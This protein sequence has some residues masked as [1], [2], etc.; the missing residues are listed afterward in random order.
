MT[1]TTAKSGEGPFVLILASAMGVSLFIF[2]ALAALSPQ[3]VADLG[4]SRAQLGALTTVLFA[5]SGV[6]A[7]VA[8]RIVDAVGGRRVLMG[9]FVLSAAG[10]AAVALS[11]S[12]V[13]MLVGVGI[14]GL[15]L[16]AANPATNHLVQ[17]FAAPGRRGVLIGLKQ[18]GV[19]VGAFAA[20]AIL[21]AAAIEVGWR[22]VLLGAAVLGLAWAVPAG[23]VLPAPPPA[24]PSSSRP[25]PAPL[26]VGRLAFYAGCMGAAIAPVGSYLPLYA[27]EQLG[28]S[29][30]V[31]GMLPAVI[32][33]IGIFS[34]VA[35][36]RYAEK[37]RSAA[38][39]LLWLAVFSVGAQLM[40]LL[41]AASPWLVWI[42]AVGFGASATSWSAVGM[43]AV[44]REASAEQAG[45]ASGWL[46]LGFHAGLVA[47]PIA[48]GAL[49]DRTGSYRWAWTLLLGCFAAAAAIAWR[50]QA[51]ERRRDAQA[52][53][54]PG[55]HLHPSTLTGNKEIT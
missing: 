25:T 2:F 29:V 13:Q 24:A 27:H 55:H 19:Q 35:W 22:A 38:P 54:W 45:R 41:A 40:I 11:R 43:L 36:G 21:P 50:W 4:F 5:V 53:P 47:S 10:M 30:V 46:V 48:L 37:G 20:G 1:D 9:L 26:R 31:A 3:I 52:D 23:K 32:G 15:A 12:Y 44:I 51:V 28:F 33:G 34:R 8:G 42:G 49:V 6:G 18:S 16:A 7:L 14:V 17:A 39:A